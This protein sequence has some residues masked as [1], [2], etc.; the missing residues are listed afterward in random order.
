MAHSGSIVH[1]GNIFQSNCTWDSNQGD[2]LQN[3][4]N[5]GDDCIH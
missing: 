3:D 1:I 4:G 5:Q 2:I